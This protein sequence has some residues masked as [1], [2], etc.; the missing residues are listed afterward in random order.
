MTCATLLSMVMICSG[1]KQSGTDSS[2][3]YPLLRVGGV[4]QHIHSM[5]IDAMGKASIFYIFPCQ[6]NLLR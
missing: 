2:T 6:C 4:T 5:K 1:E 3:R